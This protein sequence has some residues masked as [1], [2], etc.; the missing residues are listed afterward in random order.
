MSLV[1][2]REPVNTP[3]QRISIIEHAVAEGTTIHER[4]HSTTV[5]SDAEAG[6]KRFPA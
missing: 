1:Q 5:F 3:R 4:P 2:E 6:T